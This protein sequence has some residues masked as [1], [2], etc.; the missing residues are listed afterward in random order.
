MDSIASWSK[1]L[2]V[3]CVP[4][5]KIEPFDLDSVLQCLFHCPILVQNLFVSKLIQMDHNTI[6]HKFVFLL[7]KYYSGNK[8]ST[9]REYHTLAALILQLKHELNVSRTENTVSEL[10]SF[11]LETT[12]SDVKNLN[13]N[14][15]MSNNNDL[16]INTSI[17][18]Q[19]ASK[20]FTILS[21][22]IPRSTMTIIITVINMQL[23]ADFNAYNTHTKYPLIINGYI[24][25]II[26]NKH[27]PLDI[28]Q[29]IL[30]YIDKAFK[31]IK[32]FF[33]LPSDSRI[34]DIK[35]QLEKLTKIPREKYVLS[36]H[37]KT[38]PLN[39]W[40]EI[41][42]DAD[43]IKNVDE[44]LSDSDYSDID[45][46]IENVGGYDIICYIHPSDNEMKQLSYFKNAKTFVQQKIF[47]EFS[48]KLVHSWSPTF[49]IGFLIKVPAEINIPVSYIIQTIN[50][51]LK[52][53]IYSY[54]EDELPYE[55][56]IYHRLHYRFPWKDCKYK[57]DNVGC[58]GCDLNEYSKKYEYI[59]FKSSDLRCFGIRWK[60]GKEKLFDHDAFKNPIND[61]S[62]SEKYESIDELS[63]FQKQKDVTLYD[64]LDAFIDEQNEMLK[65]EMKINKFIELPQVLIIKLEKFVKNSKFKYK[66]RNNELVV[67]PLTGLNLKAYIAKNDEKKENFEYNLFA[68][69]VHSAGYNKGNGY[70]VYCKNFKDNTWYKVDTGCRDIKEINIDLDNEWDVGKITESADILFYV[71]K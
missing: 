14:N 6:I 8:I 24:R 62:V 41:Y 43:R 16:I 22:P 17:N 67:C 45:P 21:L 37:D 5:E 31:P 9:L 47:H 48:N 4:I 30:N 3:G 10:I 54:Q 42:Q 50:V 20:T 69:L 27:I 71:K 53:H 55:L 61:V 26:A 40:C 28:K 68:T 7:K 66:Y 18:V 49:G 2:P 56:F 15:T 38:G 35:M 34:I 12:H 13:E 44:E 58:D 51:M 36:Q 25:E 52:P 11:I 1:H 64:C 65:T 29:L 39:Q 70:C 59:C 63:V 46:T 32:Y 33:E 19:F 23:H 57:G 60:T